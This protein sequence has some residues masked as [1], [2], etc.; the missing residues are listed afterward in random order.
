MVGRDLDGCRRA[1]WHLVLRCNATSATTADLAHTAAVAIG[2]NLVGR[3]LA[4]DRCYLPTYPYIFLGPVW[5]ATK[6]LVKQWVIL[7]SHQW[8]QGDRVSNIR[9][10]LK[11]L[12]AHGI[13]VRLHPAVAALLATVF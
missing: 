7:I 11:L 10:A 3:L 13:E 4:V 9:E 6:H 8:L 5:Y 2:A 1:G 12:P